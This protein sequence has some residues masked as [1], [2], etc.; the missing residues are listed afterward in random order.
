MAE[1][2]SP[3]HAELRAVGQ[4][5]V[6]RGQCQG[7]GG[8]RRALS[9]RA[10]GVGVD[11]V[12]R[13]RPAPGRRGDRHAGL[14][15][16]PGDRIRRARARHAAGP[17]AGS[18]QLLHHVQPRPGRQ[19]P[20]PGVRHDAVH[21][22]RVG[23]CARRL[24]QARDEEGPHHRR[25]PVH[26]DRGRMPRR[27]RQRADG[28]DQRRQLRGSDRGQHGRDP[29]RAGRAA[30]RPSPARRSTAR[31][32]RPKAARPRSRRWPSAITIIG[33]SGRSAHHP[34]SSHP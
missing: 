10:A 7:R 8:D 33:G 13:P 28:P 9:G 6:D 31:P 23:R 17:R 5:R 27:L 18:R 34:R 3:R 1:R 25:R 21:A 26:A 24:L 11:P 29:R 12:P 15:A 30:R 19:I 4:F 14:A 32:A 22:A 20:C 16:D 2:T